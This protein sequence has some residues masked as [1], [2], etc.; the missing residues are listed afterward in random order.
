MSRKLRRSPITPVTP[1][2]RALWI[3]PGLTPFTVSSSAEQIGSLAR[4]IR[5]FD[6]EP[7]LVAPLWKEIRPSDLNI[8]KR[9][10]QIEVRFPSKTHT[11]E[12]WEGRLPGGVRVFFLDHPELFASC[13]AEDKSPDDP[14]KW[15]FL[16]MG[17]LELAKKTSLQPELIHC[18]G[19][20]TAL[21]PYLLKQQKQTAKSLATIYDAREHG[22]YPKNWVDWLGIGWDGFHLGGFEFYDQI[23]FLKAGIAYADHLSTTSQTY[24]KEICSPGGANGLEGML[25]YRSEQMTAIRHG[26]DCEQWNPQTDTFLAQPFS[27]DDFNG[28]RRCKAELQRIFRLPV[29]EGRPILSFIADATPKSELQEIL[30][31]IPQ[32]LSLGFQVVCSLTGEDSALR[33]ATIQLAHQRPD[34]VGVSLDNNEK[35]FRK[36]IGGADFFVSTSTYC[37]SA[38]E[39]M[40][41]MHYG[42]VPIVRAAGVAADLVDESL[43]FVL[44]QEED[45]FSSVLQRA[46]RAYGEN[47][48]FRQ[49]QLRCMTTDVSWQ[50][51]ASK[52]QKLYYSL[53]GR[54]LPQK[55]EE[56]TNG[57]TQMVEKFANRQSNEI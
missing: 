30:N 9:L 14:G 50:S 39:L 27:T 32:A 55:Q 2:L 4:T 53:L 20:Q 37:P 6:I 54:E 40:R 19:W 47:R 18:H 23:S 26:I 5:S 10:L 49:I 25:G 12:V 45:A 17:A 56:L 15:A 43:G 44:G 3:C 57:P 52:Y 42:A 24:M 31:A 21:A 8:A 33:D 22:C 35:L 11:A 51:T 1:K 34:A 13:S 46:H 36:I 48:N 16:T 28:R 41:A 7:T 38:P 29:R